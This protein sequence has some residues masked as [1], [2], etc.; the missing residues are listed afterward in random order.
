MK[1][2]LLLCFHIFGLQ[3]NNSLRH[4]NPLI[5]INIA[6]ILLKWQWHC[7]LKRKDPI[8]HS[9]RDKYSVSPLLVM[10][11]CSPAI[12]PCNLLCRD[13]AKYIDSANGE[14]QHQDIKE[15]A[16]LH[17]SNTTGKRQTK[18]DSTSLWPLSWS[19]HRVLW[20][21]LSTKTGLQ[22]RLVVTLKLW[23]YVESWP[24]CIGQNE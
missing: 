20:P 24:K 9:S 15:N 19:W 5:T 13:I 10:F 21:T 18:A 17:D 14:I 3:M 11:N 1:S 8:K 2:F 12:S 23:L 4:Y 22:Y 7:K 16:I 6:H